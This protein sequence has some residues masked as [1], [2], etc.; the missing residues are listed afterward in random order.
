MKTAGCFHTPLS[1]GFFHTPQPRLP[2]GGILEVFASAGI[3]VGGSGP[4]RK[5]RCPFHDDKHP[6]AVLFVED[7]TFHCSPCSISLT[8]KQCAERLG[9]PWR[10][11]PAFPGDFIRPAM[12]RKRPEP[13]LFTPADA[14][15]LWISAVAEIRDDSRFEANAKSFSFL[16]RRGVE[17]ALDCGEDLVGFLP[18]QKSHPSISSWYASMSRPWGYGVVV[19]LFDDAG[20]IQNVQARA[21]VAPIPAG[22]KKILFP[23]GSQARGARF[24]NRA[25]RSLLSGEACAAKLVV[26]GEGM[27]DFISLAIVKPSVPIFAAPGVEFMPQIVGPWAKGRAVYVGAHVDEAGERGAIDTARR[28]FEMGGKPKRLRWPAGAKDC[29]DALALFGL[30]E[31]EAELLAL[32]AGAQGVTK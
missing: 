21:S 29:N 5:I 27:L 14:E 16:A 6:S 30:D 22:A 24:A 15:R 1:S 26:V 9:V 23:K 4:K 32:L 12:E 8:A 7:N 3:P 18:H 17:S 2:P 11:K 10:G 28:V 20:H 31:F 13:L 25:G 19:P